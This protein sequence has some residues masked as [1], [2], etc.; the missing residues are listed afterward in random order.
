M[1]IS[2]SGIDDS[3]SAE[4]PEGDCAVKRVDLRGGISGRIQ[5]RESCRRSAG[6]RRTT[7]FMMS[8]VGDQRRVITS[9]VAGDVHVVDEADNRLHSWKRKIRQVAVRV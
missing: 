1:A 2:D 7:G 5:K 3:L 8:S 4:A 9:F 6:R